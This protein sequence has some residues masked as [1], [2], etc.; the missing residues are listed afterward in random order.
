[1]HYLDGISFIVPVNNDDIL[2]NS[3]L[4]S[5]LFQ[6]DFLHEI[7]IQTGYESASKAYNS[8]IQSTKYDLNIFLH[9]DIILPKFWLKELWYSINWLND[10]NIPWGVLGVYG[11][12][13]FGVGHGFMY[14]GG[15]K[16]WMGYLSTLPNLIQTLDEVVLITN[17]NN[18]LFFDERLPGYHLYGADLCMESEIRSYNNYAI[19]AFCYHNTKKINYLP[20]S[21][22]DAFKYLKR[23]WHTKLPIDTTCSSIKRYDLLGY[24]KMR[25]YIRYK[26]KVIDITKSCKK[27]SENSLTSQNA[28]E[29]ISKLSD[30]R[31]LTRFI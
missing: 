5:P 25:F 17:K 8:A 7:I 3:F 1:M 16:R 19:P 6:Q 31:V 9:Q 30:E 20:D 12:D 23:K 26:E 4:S 18:N 13:K 14:C 11:H 29:I 10:N 27:R 15:N 22:F 24:L 2:K 21:Y 28:S